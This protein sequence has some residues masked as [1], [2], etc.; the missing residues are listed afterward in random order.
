MQNEKEIV[1]KITPEEVAPQILEEAR[2]AGIR[3]L[4]L[5]SQPPA[6]LSANGFSLVVL[7]NLPGPDH[8]SWVKVTDASDLARAVQIGALNQAFVVVECTDWKIIPLENLIA[9][10]KRIG[11]KIYASVDSGAE[12]ETAFTVLEKGVDGVVIGP[13]SLGAAARFSDPARP[14]FVLAPA[15][16][17]KIV[18]AGL[19]DRACIDTTSKLDLGEGMLVGSVGSFFFLVHGETLSSEYIPARPFR[20]N[21]G[22]LHS[23]V[24]GSD[25]RTKYL[26]ELESPDRVTIVDRGGNARDAS[27]GRVKIERR[28]LVLIGASTAD[29]SGTVILQKAETIRLVRSDGTPVSV[30]ELKR[31]DEVLTHS[32]ST[33]G[34]HFGGEVDEHIEEK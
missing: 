7:S 25:G 4:L 12:I 5:E 16:I 11:R 19:G 17:T 18:D 10:F 6:G 27:I 3:R 23:Y 1:L 15:R 32:A 34:R 2:Q 13:S 22:A 31:G 26:S 28:P 33:M 14:V 21:A 29:R 9:E 30:T 24:L 20:V 8:A